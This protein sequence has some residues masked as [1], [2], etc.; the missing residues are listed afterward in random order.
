VLDRR[1]FFK[2]FSGLN[3]DQKRYFGG[4]GVTKI[5]FFFVKKIIRGISP[6]WHQVVEKKKRR[7]LTEKIVWLG[8]AFESL[9]FLSQPMPPRLKSIPSRECFIFPRLVMLSK[10]IDALSKNSGLEN[11]SNTNFLFFFVRNN[12]TRFLLAIASA[13]RHLAGTHTDRRVNC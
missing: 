13:V 10:K 4:F 1:C 2:A 6:N 9:H 3:Y 12:L 5:K 8:L 7:Q 11:V